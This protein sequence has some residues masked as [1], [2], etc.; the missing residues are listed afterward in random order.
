MNAESI[1]NRI[2]EFYGFKKDIELADFLGVQ[3]NTIATWKVRNSV[4]MRTIISKCR[5]INMDYVLGDSDSFHVEEEGEKGDLKILLAGKDIP[6]EDLKI[7]Y[8]EMAVP[9][10]LPQGV[11]EDVQTYF[12]P[13][14]RFHRN[15]FIVRVVGDSMEGMRIFQG[16]E[17]LV[18]TTVKPKNG[19]VVVARVYGEVTLKRYKKENGVLL[20]HPENEGYKPIIVNEGVEVLGVVKKI[21]RDL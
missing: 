14:K 1:I 12:Y 8:F 3:P 6:D 9:A 18:D 20:L 5:G 21:M 10:G 17:L 7:R 4:N 16:D 13:R 19:D 15:T 2:K 11:S